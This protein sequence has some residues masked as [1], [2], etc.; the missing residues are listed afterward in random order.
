MSIPTPQSSPTDSTGVQWRL[1]K[2]E[3]SSIF[4]PVDEFILKDWADSA[5]IAPDDQVDR[6]DDQWQSAP[7]I[8]FLE[9]VWEVV[10]ESGQPYGPTTWGTLTEFLKEG[11]VSPKTEA[12]HTQTNETKLLNDIVVA[13][14]KETYPTPPPPEP[15]TTVSPEQLAPTN[16]SQSGLLIV[17]IA[18]DQR[19]RQMEEDL[20][21][22][23]K[24]HEELLQK[25]RTL[26]K[27]AVELR[28]KLR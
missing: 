5:Q 1:K 4:G 19:I 11:L 15:G 28:T 7:K 3:D 2:A 6:G 20:R 12:T 8:E 18:K 25:Y 26:N 9:M 17:D 21:S 16:P 24:E 27:E 10:L 14:L 23:K 13:N 22:L